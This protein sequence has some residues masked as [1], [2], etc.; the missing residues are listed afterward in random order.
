MFRA[1]RANIIHSFDGYLVRAV[2]LQLGY[3]IITIHDSFGIDILN[4]ERLLSI[5]QNEL[6]KLATFHIFRHNTD[7]RQEVVVNS[8]YVLL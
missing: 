1:V 8:E 6:N 7:M 2:T 5:T 4:V 3:P